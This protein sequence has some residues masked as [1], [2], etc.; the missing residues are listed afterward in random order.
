MVANTLNFSHARRFAA[1]L[2]FPVRTRGHTLICGRRLHTR[3]RSRSSCEDPLRHTGR[4]RSQAR[5]AARGLR[6]PMGD[7]VEEPGRMAAASAGAGVSRIHLRASSAASSSHVKCTHAAFIS[8]LLCSAPPRQGL[9]LLGGMDH[10]AKSHRLG[11]SGA[12]ASAHVRCIRQQL[13]G[14]AWSHAAP[15]LSG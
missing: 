15:F 14:A 11:A 13:N 2:R 4:H 5:R 9:C 12:A 3:A 6:G 7:F 8:S 10:D 1:S